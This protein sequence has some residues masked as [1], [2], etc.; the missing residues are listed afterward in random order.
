MVVVEDTAMPPAVVDYVAA[1]EKFDKAFTSSV[2]CFKCADGTACIYSPL[3][4]DAYSDVRVYFRA[5][6][7]GI[8]RAIEAGFKKPALVVPT[9]RRFQNAELSS[10]LGALAGLY[11]PIQYREAAKANEARVEQLFVMQNSQ[12]AL[13]HLMD[14]TIALESGLFVSRDI[15][16]G[17]PERMAPPR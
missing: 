14:A 11:V 4:L 3:H 2:S 16:G 10:M 13:N 5:A 6:K 12:K 8:E 7:A 9:S 1:A 15:G 17:D